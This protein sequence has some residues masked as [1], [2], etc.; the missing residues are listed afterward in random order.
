M[1]KEVKVSN[2]LVPIIG[3]FLIMI[4][5]LIIQ[6]KVLQLGEMPLEMIFMFA[7]AIGT[8]N[9]YFMGYTWD[10]IQESMVKKITQGL[11]AM[12]ILFSIGV[13]VG[14]WI[15]S[16]T[17]PMLIYYGIKIMNPKYIYVIAFI[18][19]IIFSTLTG[20]SWGS[21]GTIGIVIMGIAQVTGA[22]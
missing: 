15:V 3:L 6:P 16:G 17:I 5:G 7:A 20:T 11:P 14:A 19:P 2:A 9:L 10:E 4:Y 22:L 8:A 21:V 18:V 1:K 12:M 13:V